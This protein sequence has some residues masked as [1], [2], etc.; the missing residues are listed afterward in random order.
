M[1][2]FRNIRKNFPPSPPPAKRHR[3][4]GIDVGSSSSDDDDEEQI[5]SF[6]CQFLLYY[7]ASFL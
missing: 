2:N 1:W 7:F 4:Y 5:R 6:F 3:G